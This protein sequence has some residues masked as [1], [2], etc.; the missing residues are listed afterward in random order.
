MIVL[1]W[2]DRN[3]ADAFG[4]LAPAPGGAFGSRSWTSTDWGPVLD[5]RSWC[6]C[7]VVEDREVGYGVLVSGVIDHVQLAAEPTADSSEMITMNPA[8]G[9]LRGR[10]VAVEGAGRLPRNRSPGGSGAQ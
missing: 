3:L 4:G 1:D 8:L 9:R 5:G 10:Y 7:N 2:A 6:G